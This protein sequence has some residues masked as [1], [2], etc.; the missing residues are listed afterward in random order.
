MLP[1]T[2]GADG[3]S[4]QVRPWRRETG[5]IITGWLLQIVVFLAVVSVLVFEVVAIGVAHVS[6]DETGRE[7]GRVARDAYRDQRSLDVA[8]EAVERSLAG[9]TA[10][11]AE[12]EV[13][14]DEV[15]LTLTMPART[16]LVHR[17]GPIADLATAETTRR[18]RW[19]P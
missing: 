6:V 4:R 19:R 15:V 3:R 18:V 2:A 11:L 8:R 7:V 17:V 14:G 10:A 16:L 5:G 9:R 12:L 1:P 13:E